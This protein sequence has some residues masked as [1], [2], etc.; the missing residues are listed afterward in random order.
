MRVLDR[1]KIQNTGVAWQ[2]CQYSFWAILQ[3]QLNQAEAHSGACKSPGSS[4]S[5]ALRV[6]DGRSSC[7]DR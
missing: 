2:A 4:A 5:E 7:P 6:L 1:D 3:K